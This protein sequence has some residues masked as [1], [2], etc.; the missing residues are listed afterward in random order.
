MF[1]FHYELR[2]HM[3]MMHRGKMASGAGRIESMEDD[4]AQDADLPEFPGNEGVDM[5]AGVDSKVPANVAS[6]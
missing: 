6:C 5:T 1:T 4:S 3:K 2:N